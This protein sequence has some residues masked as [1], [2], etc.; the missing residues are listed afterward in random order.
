MGPMANPLL[1]LADVLTNARLPQVVTRADGR[2]SI[3]P[4]Q[5]W[6]I[7]FPSPM[8]MPAAGELVVRRE[9]YEPATLPLIADPKWSGGDAQLLAGDITNL[10]CFAAKLKASADPVSTWLLGKFSQNARAAL[11]NYPASGLDSAILQSILVKE[12][13]AVINGPVIYETNRFRGVALSQAALDLMEHERRLMATPLYSEAYLASTVPLARAELNRQL[14]MDAHPG[15]FSGKR[16]SG[17]YKNVGV[18][19]LTPIKK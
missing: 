2:F 1:P 7:Y 11:A 6:V 16:G 13:D 5:R 10:A 8:M 4:A 19:L 17:Y 12:L 18:V 15:V 14:L 3:R 9:G